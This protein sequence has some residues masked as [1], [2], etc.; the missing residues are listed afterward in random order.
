MN[1]QATAAGEDPAELRR[2]RDEYRTLL[3]AFAQP[4]RSAVNMLGRREGT[5]AAELA[6]ELRDLLIRAEGA[7]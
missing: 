6:D 1:A 3:G 2:Q 7:Q 5:A 4:V